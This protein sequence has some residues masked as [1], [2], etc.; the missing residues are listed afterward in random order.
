MTVGMH[1]WLVLDAGPGQEPVFFSGGLFGAP[2]SSDGYRK[3]KGFGE[4]VFNT[5]MTGYQEILTDP[6]Y[7]GQMVCM[8]TAHIGNTGIN[9]EDVESGRP[10]ASG[11]IVREYCSQPS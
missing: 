6:S 9:A 2:L 7:F 3:D 11:F 1:G 4:V 8:T 5:S 10:W